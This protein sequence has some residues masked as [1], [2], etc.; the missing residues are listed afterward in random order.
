MKE[1]LLQKQIYKVCAKPN[2]THHVCGLWLHGPTP[3]T[4]IQQ[5]DCNMAVLRNNV[6]TIR[7]DNSGQLSATSLLV[8]KTFLRRSSVH[9]SHPVASFSLLLLPLAICSYCLLLFAP[10][11]SC[12]LFLLLIAFCSCYRLLFVPVTSCYFPWY[13]CPY[14]VPILLYLV[15]RLTLKKHTS[16]KNWQLHFFQGRSLTTTPTDLCCHANSSASEIRGY[17]SGDNEKCLLR[18]IRVVW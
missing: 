4:H 7:D 1:S 10:V 14:L 12:Y 9:L 3:S 2:K 8:L 6:K 18:G 16:H 15:G 17:H 11:T 5:N 13:S